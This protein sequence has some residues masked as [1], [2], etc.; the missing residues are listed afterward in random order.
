MRGQLDAVAATIFQ[1]VKEAGGLPPVGDAGTGTSH[2][3][4]GVVAALDRPAAFE[5]S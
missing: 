4:A 2:H 5:L 3:L 1:K